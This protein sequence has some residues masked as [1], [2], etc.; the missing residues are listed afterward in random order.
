[1]GLLPVFVNKVLSEH[2][3]FIH[4][5][6]TQAE[7]STCDKDHTAYKTKWPYLSLYKKKLTRS[8]ESEES[9]SEDSFPSLSHY[10]S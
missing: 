5:R 10:T 6:A 7:F 3:H 4:V 8:E 1:M 2:S 9:R